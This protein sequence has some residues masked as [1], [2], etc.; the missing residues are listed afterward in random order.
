MLDLIV[1]VSNTF[2]F[3][4]NGKIYPSNASDEYCIGIGESSD[5]N[6]YDPNNGKI[7]VGKCNY[8]TEFEY[9]TTNYIIILAEDKDQCLNIGDGD[10][11]NDNGAY[12]VLFWIYKNKLNQCLF[13][14][15]QFTYRP[16]ISEYK[17][18]IVMRDCNHYTEVRTSL[19][20]KKCD[21][22][23]GKIIKCSSNQ[24]CGKNGTCGVG[25]NYCSTKKDCQSKYGRCN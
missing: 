9:N 13:T 7:K 21:T 20:V 19:P 8:A 1:I 24:C 16:T 22:I 12:L 23:N 4:N 5:I 18:I 14:G 2:I 11:T 3:K 17:G 25:N 15:S 10:P 6:F